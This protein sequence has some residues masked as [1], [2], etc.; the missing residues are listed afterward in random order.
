MRIDSATLRPGPSLT[1]SQRVIGLGYGL[2]GSPLYLALAGA[3][4][5]VDPVTDRRLGM[6]QVPGLRQADYVMTLAA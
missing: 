1:V 5:A 6:F 3:V 2:E 4:E